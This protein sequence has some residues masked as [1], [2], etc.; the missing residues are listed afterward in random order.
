MINE[1]DIVAKI[2]GINAAE[3][4]IMAS[5]INLQLDQHGID[6]AQVLNLLSKEPGELIGE[7]EKLDERRRQVKMDLRK[8]LMK[9]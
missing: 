5:E 6:P 4:K 1:K 2:P 8:R 3:A 9:K 7:I